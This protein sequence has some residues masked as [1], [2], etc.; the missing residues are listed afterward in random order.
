M[1]SSEAIRLT[2]DGIT[3]FDPVF[4]KPDE[5]TYT[6]LESPVLTRLMRLRI[7]EPSPAK[8]HPDATTSE[9]EPCFAADGSAYAFI[10]SRANLNMKLVIRETATGKDAIFD[11]GGGFAAVRR[12]SLHPGENGL[13]SPCRRR[14]GRRSFRS[15]GMERIARH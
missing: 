3:K 6:V 12:P 1:S 13:S 8:L 11:P 5:I 4:T 2:V 14:R 9:F 15:P 10:Q 7:G